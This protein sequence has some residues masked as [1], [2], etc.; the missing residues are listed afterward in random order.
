[1]ETQYS[2]PL[3]KLIEEFQ[4]SEIYL[5]TPAEEILIKS[6]EVARP[7]LAFAGF[8]EIFD[9]FRIQIIGRTEHRYAF[10]HFFS[11]VLSV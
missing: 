10:S 4:L 2:I 6:P 9:T 11:S 1:M 8:T 3:S 7:G 5:P